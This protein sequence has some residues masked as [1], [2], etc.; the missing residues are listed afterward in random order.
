MA[1]V[2]VEEIASKKFKN[3]KFKK[4]LLFSTKLRR[5]L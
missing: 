2:K 3:R 5:D 4:N 1:P